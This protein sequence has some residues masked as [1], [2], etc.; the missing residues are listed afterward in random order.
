MQKQTQH[1]KHSL[2]GEIVLAQFVV[3]L[4]QG[5]PQ[6]DALLH[7]FLVVVQLLGNAQHPLLAFRQFLDVVQ[8]GVQLPLDG[9][10]V[11]VGLS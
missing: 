7:F 1:T 6:G 3:E 5:L 11:V 8:L 10:A 9:L 4:I 2:C